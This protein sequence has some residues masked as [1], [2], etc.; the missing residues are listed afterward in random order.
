MYPIFTSQM[1]WAALPRVAA[2]G[3]QV[4][5]AVDLAASQDLYRLA[6][7]KAQ[8]SVARSRFTRRVLGS[9]SSQNVWN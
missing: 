2:A 1:A 7:A 8:E 4:A 5:Q 9:A 6:Y 3:G